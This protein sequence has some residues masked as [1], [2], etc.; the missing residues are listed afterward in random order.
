MTDREKQRVAI[1]RSQGE[2][3]NAIAVALN[4]SVNSVKTFC[5][6]SHL[7]GTRAT[8]T[9]SEVS[10][11]NDLIDVEN[12]GNTVNAETL[13]YAEKAGVPAPRTACKV[14]LVF[15]D[16]PDEGAI[17]DVLGMLISS[18]FRRGKTV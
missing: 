18:R 16:T 14:K 12:R 1:L 7:T 17:Q 6:R 8:E 11:S 3:Y 2:S 9:I 5:R 13:T 15:S 4:V 10:P